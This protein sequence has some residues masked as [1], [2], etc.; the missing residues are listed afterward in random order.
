MNNYLKKTLTVITAFSLSLPY[1]VTPVADIFS[2]EEN[3][4]TGFLPALPEFTHLTGQSDLFLTAGGKEIENIAVP[5]SRAVM[6]S[7]F[8]MRDKGTI[9]SVK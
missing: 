1:C 7:S 9:S 4:E 3:S 8:D 2:I 6:P 5:Y